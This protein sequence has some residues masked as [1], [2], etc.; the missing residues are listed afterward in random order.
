[1]VEANALCANG[2]SVW[3]GARQVLHDVSFIAEVGHITA[4]L[5]P[6]GAGKST[7]L[8]ALCGLQRYRGR[9]SLG[10]QCI[11]A[12]AAHERARDIS[13]VPQHSQ[14]VA[15][16][17]VWEVVALGRYAHRGGVA[18]LS[19]QDRTHI[20]HAMQEADV[21]RFMDRSFSELSFGEQKRVLIAR[22]L[23]TGAGYLL[24]DEPTASLDIEHA[25]RLFELLTALAEQGRSIVVV[26][27][28]L[29]EAYKFSHRSL[30]LKEGRVVASGP[31]REIISPERV[32]ELYGVEL[33]PGGALG[34]RLPGHT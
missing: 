7:L 28:Q 10:S 11:D 3:R 15:A 34:F 20:E 19:D 18:R 5:G 25:L 31:S 21:A 6:N 23:C 22:A 16:M 33:V 29:D 27:H 30:L 2:L 13:F 24:L 1:M 14:L 9:V 12:M 26:L 8:R 32:R 17:P 4:V